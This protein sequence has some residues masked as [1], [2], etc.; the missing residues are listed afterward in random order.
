MRRIAVVPRRLANAFIVLFG[1]HG[2]ISREA[3]R[4][5]RCRIKNAMIKPIKPNT[6]PEA[7]VM[8][9]EGLKQIPAMLLPSPQGHLGLLDRKASPGA[10]CLR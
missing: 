1:E 6:A 9:V 7:P 5:L 3:G 8:T 10:L 4:V 2:D